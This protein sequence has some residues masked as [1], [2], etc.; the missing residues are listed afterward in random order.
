MADLATVA[1]LEARLERDLDGTEITRAEALLKG[2]SA[3]V[4][5]YTGQQF[6]LVADDEQRIRVKSGKV[7]LPQRPVTAVSSIADMSGNDVAFT[8][9][10]GDLVHLDALGV[11]PRFDLEPYRSPPAWVD[12]TYSHGYTTIPD[13]VVEVVCQMA[14]RAFG[15]PAE[16]SGISRESIDDYSYSVGAAAA[17][18]ALGM[19][20]DERAALDVYRRRG[21]TIRVST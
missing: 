19:L 6:D 14:L 12:V 8:W 2:A 10:A 4:R 11:I 20:S 13:D 7:R 16:T 3:R 17:S 18:G 1:D 21:G 9:H 5:S 15:T